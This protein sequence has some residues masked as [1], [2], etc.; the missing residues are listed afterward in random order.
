MKKKISG[1]I[2]LLGRSG[3]YNPTEHSRQVR[4]KSRFTNQE[5]FSLAKVISVAILVIGNAMLLPTLFVEIS[6]QQINTTNFEITHGIA[7]GDVTDHSAIIWSRVNDQPAQMNVEYDTDA[8]F[9]NPLRETTQ[10]NSTTDF[11]A[12]A[13]LEGLRP[14]TQ[15]Y[16][17]VWFTGSDIENNYNTISN[18][19]SS[20][21]S[22]NAEKVEIGTFR[23]APSRNMSSN[24]SGISFVWSADL[25]GQNYCRNA[26]EGGYSIFKSMQ[27]LNPDFFIANGDMIYADGACPA[28]GPIFLNNTNN[29]TITWTNIPDDFKSLA[30]PS[31]N[32]NNITEVRTIF[33]DHWKYN[34]NDTYFKEFLSNVS[35]YSQWDDHEIIND[36]GSKWP[37]WNLFSI[38]REGYPNIVKEGTNAFLYY[39]PLEIDKNTSNDTANVRDGH[40]YRSFNWGKNLDLFIIDARSYRSQNHITDTPDNNKTM[41]GEEQ[42]Q[43]LKQELS[44]SNATWKVI[45]SDVPISIPT[46]S[47]ASILGRDGWANG[48][49]TNNYSYYTGF[50]RELTD[51]LGF[52]DEQEIKNIVF[53]TTDVH[54]P[55][56]IRYDFDL[57]NDGNTTEI[58]EFVSGPLSAFRLG[59]PFPML[60]ETFNPTLLYGEGNIFNFGHIR[61]EDR[62]DNDEDEN[63]KPHLI[64]DIRDENGIVR[65]GSTLDLIPQ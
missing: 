20:T 61:I 14:D 65:P 22:D 64:A 5:L 15:Y 28:E 29:Q 25:G 6:A 50:E 21:T 12:Y 11:T 9:N 41:L 19:N 23:T 57:N 34:R 33:L 58:H 40:I 26:N 49:E 54:F 2:G 46:G 18:N 10:A 37:Y 52:I 63:G 7:S 45:S 42:L 32:W 47:N 30:D 39:S 59:V 48:N 38:D 3:I 44:N 56:L 8:N 62:R 43:W 16:Y 31:V 13:K 27:A 36:F 55:A 35:M 4:P 1:R 24:S 51:L 60:D 17:R 53:I